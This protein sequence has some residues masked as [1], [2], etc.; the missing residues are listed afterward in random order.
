MI[1]S[2]PLN[3]Q[4]SL[5]VGEPCKVPCESLR[6]AL[7]VKEKTDFL[8]SQISIVRDSV[9]LYKDIIN[10]KDTLIKYKDS[11]ITVLKINQ[12]HFQETV[13]IQEKVIEEARFD[14]IVA[15]VISGMSFLVTLAAIL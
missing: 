12:K 5:V 8:D 3:S 7:K 13:N 2:L 4:V 6:N 1:A 14:K 9:I 10:V 15:Y 11:Q